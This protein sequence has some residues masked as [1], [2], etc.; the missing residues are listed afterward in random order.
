VTATE[1]I[2]AGFALAY[3]WYYLAPG[4]TSF[5][6]VPNNTDFN[7]VTTATLDILNPISYDNYQFYCQVRENTATCYQASNAVKIDGITA[8]WNGVTSTWS[9]PPTIGRYAI[10]DGN[11]N[12]S[13]GGTQVSFSACGLMVNSG[14]SLDIQNGDYIEVEN[15]IVAN[16]D[17]TVFPQG[18]V[19]QINDLATVT[20]SGTMTVQ[21]LTS[22]LNTPYDYTYWSS[23]VAGETIE[24]VFSTVPAN[25]RFFF[26]ASNFIDTQI[27]IANTGTFT[28]GQDDIDDDGNDWQ[29]A[30]S[31][32]LPG[33][34][35]AAT[36]STFGPA[37][38][39]NQQFPF[40]GPFNNGVITPTISYVA[41]SPYK[42]W[43]FIGNPYPSA[44][45]TAT[46]FSVNSGITN[47]IYLWSHATP[48]DVNA[49]GN[50]GYNFSGS[51][52]AVISGSGVNNPGG[53]G[54]I[55]ANFVPSGQ[56]FFIEALNNGPITFNNSIRV[57]G[58]NDQFFRNSVT[59]INNRQV[60]WV[61]LRS[62][63]GVTNYLTVAHIEGATDTNDGSYYDVERNISTQ[64]FAKIYSLIN[65][66]DSEYLIQG[67]SPSSLDLDE[68]INLGFS[69]FIESATIYTI[70]IHQFEGDF[71]SDNAIYLKD[72]LLNVTHNLKDSDYNFTSETGVFN[73]RFEIV[74][75]PS[76]LS[77]DDNLVD[78]NDLIIT[79]LSNGDVQFKIDAKLAISNVTILDV[80]G[81]EVYNLQ[82]S[83]SIEVYDLSKLS[84]AAYIAKVTLSNGQV[85]SKKAIK[86][87]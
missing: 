20:G 26:N 40:V 42:D 41:G 4:A 5:V 65:G 12:T 62:D 84:N 60:L 44:I 72:N 28:P 75:T 31:T 35:Y 2:P 1:G 14:F 67:K 13:V 52:Y 83:N 34:G 77:V 61:K 69:T 9:A 85:L 15:D 37:L 86:Q 8:V 74:F 16:G 7:N 23:P 71:Y 30:S 57:T 51:D 59:N 33:V 55:P 54:I 39:T 11:Y 87:L 10:I 32:M 70:S 43:N 47:A 66:S 63:N 25:R 27:E 78:A 22:V 18:S 73:S 48:E 64:S 21:K 80:L 3:Q 58:S 56:G 29:L 81:R 45:S 68:V 53:D 49:S 24:N 19:V 79:E 82:G 6:I 36:P 38:P 17:I 50:E 46:F 76:A